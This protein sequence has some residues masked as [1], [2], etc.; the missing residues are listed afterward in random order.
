MYGEH[1][2]LFSGPRGTAFAAVIALHVLAGF[3]F[4]SGLGATL[5]KQLE[6]PPIDLAPPSARPSVSIDVP[7]ATIATIHVQ[8]TDPPTARIE[9]GDAPTQVDLGPAGPPLEMEPPAPMVRV[10]A[11]MDAKHPVRIPDDA[12]PDA[13]K[14]NNESGRCTVDVTVASDGRIVAAQVRTGTGFERLDKACV[15]A[16]IGQHMAPATEDGKPVQGTA[17]FPITWRLKDK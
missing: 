5:L 6:P 4:Y 13:A 3:A 16:V 14:R 9:T 10:A 8:A 2:P 12:Y 11:H 7:K 1:S 15:D 17:S